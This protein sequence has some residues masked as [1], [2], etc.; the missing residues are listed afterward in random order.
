MPYDKKP[1]MIIFDVGGTLFDD[2]P[3]KPIDGL[4]HLRLA[5]SNP[6]VTDDNTLA[7]LWDKYM[8]DISSLKSKS[9]VSLDMPLT[10]PLRYVSMRT[11][12]RF[13]ISTPEQEEVFDRYN[14]SRKVI[15]GIPE[16]LDTLHSLSIRTAVISNNAMSSAGLSLALKSWIP[17]ESFEFVLTSADILYCKPCKDIFLSALVYAGLE[18]SD[19]WYCGDGFVPDV[20]GSSGVGITPVLI[21]TKAENEFEINQ[22]NG[23]EYITV[24]NWYALRNYILK[25]AE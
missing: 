2:G 24:N 5:S 4:S 17:D 3:C 8:N 18:P 10:A 22:V 25:I 20:I 1:E 21:N 13:D 15:D 23:S 19:C 7:L 11:G 6:E 9:G 12:L 16:L 14:S